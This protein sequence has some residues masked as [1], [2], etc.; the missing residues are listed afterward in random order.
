[1][2]IVAARIDMKEREF[3]AALQG[4]FPKARLGDDA[5][6]HLLQRDLPYGV[7][8]LSTD[9]VV[10]GVHFD[11]RYGSLSQA[12]Q[13]L[14]TSNV[15][16]IYAMGGS[17]RAILF[18]AGLPRGCTPGDAKEIIDGLKKGTSFYGISLV[19][20][21]T[22][23]SAAAFFFNISII[24]AQDVVMPV[25]RGGAGIG[26][27]LVLFGTCGGSLLGL[28][29]LQHLSGVRKTERLPK[30]LAA[31]LPPWDEICGT[32]SELSIDTGEEGIGLLAGDRS[33]AVRCLLAL[34]NRHLAPETRPVPPDLLRVNPPVVT[35]MIDVSDGLARDVRNLCGAS[36]VGAVLHEESLPVPEAL[37]QMLGGQGEF[38]SELALSSGEEYVMLAACRERPPGGTVIGEIVPEGEGIEFVGRDGRKRE[39]PDTGYEH[40]F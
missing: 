4:A 26:D 7:M 24:G 14:V 25:P 36:R 6:S 1:V 34:A 28:T 15:S 27:L 19:G 11:R 40:R 17:P 32:L 2:G 29:L 22:V 8:V 35:A 31:E 5:A 23:E 3:I 30:S 13:K 16:D 10:E 39:L 37:S 38:R 18:T 9:A 20:G 33:G 12:V 21:D